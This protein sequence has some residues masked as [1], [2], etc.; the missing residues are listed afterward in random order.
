MDV[1]CM[2]NWYE[3][4][5]LE[6]SNLWS[7]HFLIG[8]RWAHSW[9]WS[10][11]KWKWSRVHTRDTLGNWGVYA[12]LL[13]SRERAGPLDGMCIRKRP[14][15]TSSSERLSTK[16]ELHFTSLGTVCVSVICFIFGPKFWAYGWFLWSVEIKVPCVSNRTNL[17][18]NFPRTEIF[19]N[20]MIPD[21][22][23]F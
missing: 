19:E 10:S 2:L 7:T 14:A 4:S 23:F 1:A 5:F 21:T 9:L 17:E 12:V 13:D 3:H 18:S 15:R 8:Y 22:Y 20:R 6:M 16:E 11:H